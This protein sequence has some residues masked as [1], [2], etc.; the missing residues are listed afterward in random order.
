MSLSKEFIKWCAGQAV[1]VLENYSDDDN[2]QDLINRIAEYT[3]D[4]NLAWELYCF[5]PAI[6]CRLFFREPKYPDT[7]TL[8][9]HDTR[10]LDV[11]LQEF[12]SFKIAIE[13]IIEALENDK[14]DDKIEKI[15]FLSPDLHALNKAV[16]KEG[17]Q[18]K[19]VKIFPIVLNAP[20]G[21][22]FKQGSVGK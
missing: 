9:M 17:N 1:N 3:K 21:Y 14:N 16:N 5:I 22:E 12:E 10:K 2:E 15:L 11:K 19:D 20:K 8:V 7:V 6:Y 4:Y 18:M 13:A